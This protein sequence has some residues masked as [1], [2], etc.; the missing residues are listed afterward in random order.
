L[1]R[2][3]DALE[4][5]LD[6][7]ARIESANVGKPMAVSRDDVAFSA[8]NL[9][10]FAGAAQTLEG[11]AAGEYIADHTSFIR[12][13]PVGV[14]ASIAPWN[15]PLLM[16]AWKIGPALAAGNTVVVKPSEVTPLSTL[17]VAQL[18]ADILPPGVLNVVTGQGQ[19]VGAPLVSHPDVALVSLTGSLTTGQA[20]MRAAADTVKRVHLELGGKA[21]LL[22]LPDADIEAVA[23]GIRRS[24]FYN[25][26]QDCTAVTRVLVP[27]RRRS[28]LLDA[29]IPLVEAIEVGD[30][31][32]DGEA[33]IDMG[34][35]VSRA[36]LDHVQAM[37]Q[38]AQAA[39]ATAVT[40]GTMLD[41]PGWFFSPTVLTDVAQDAEVVQREVFGPVI[42]VQ[43]YDSVPEAVEMANDNPFALAASVWGRDLGATLRLAN[44]VQAGTVW[45]NQ[46][47]RLT[48]EMPHGGSKRSGFGNDM[49]IYALEE[50]TTIKHV[51]VRLPTGPI[52]DALS[53]A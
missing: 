17:R 50:Y 37:T 33:K 7:L 52:D 45:I 41:R 15:Y 46:H 28:E 11:R 26:G 40:G 5:D 34:P 24:A 8:D 47:T 49:S 12:R 53:R 25:S 13:E 10:F 16:L 35:L 2:L 30:P 31:L 29:L 43:S 3:A 14:V 36:H 19:A 39:G 23:A 51:M 21:P 27:T 32:A 20:I 4:G 44:E 1:H 18:S 38:R 48:P 22:M 42:T 6:N 9:R